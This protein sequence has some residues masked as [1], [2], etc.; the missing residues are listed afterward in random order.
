MIEFRMGGRRIRPDQFSKELEKATKEMALE[1]IKKKLRSIR[2]PK[3]GEKP[4]I[5]LK[6]DKIEISGSDSVM[7]QV[8]KRLK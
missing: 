1:E 3:T 8:N 7:E 6:G 4:K 5:T 2:D